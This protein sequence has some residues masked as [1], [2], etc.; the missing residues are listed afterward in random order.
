VPQS[1]KSARG[2]LDLVGHYQAAV[3]GIACLGH[4]LTLAF[5]PA[6]L[7]RLGFGLVILAMPMAFVGFFAVKR[8]RVQSLFQDDDPAF[9]RWGGRALAAYCVAN[10]VWVFGSHFL[11]GEATRVDGAYVFR[12]SAKHVL[13]PATLADFRAE[14]GR[15]IRALTAFMMLFSGF[16][17]LDRLRYLEILP[18]WSKRQR[19]SVHPRPEVPPDDRYPDLDSGVDLR[20]GW[21]TRLRMGVVTLALLMPL[22]VTAAFWRNGGHVARFFAAAV[23]VPLVVRIFVSCFFILYPLRVA[24][25]SQEGLWLIEAGWIPWHSI[26]LLKLRVSQLESSVRIHLKPDA[27]IPD[28]PL[29]ARPTHWLSSSRRRG[30]AALGARDV[31]LDAEV[32]LR[33]A[34]QRHGVRVVPES[35]VK[36]SA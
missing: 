21:R 11:W 19:E 13:G 24:R 25:V 23:G 35:I 16:S 15:F 12:D 27:E 4:V 36:R 9:L 3:F 7:G 1:T 26:A 17:L 10:F 29:W 2:R 5:M 31:G 34:S 6:S 18:T 22:G 30:F 8:N 33:Y 20:P 32:W 14:Q 28:V